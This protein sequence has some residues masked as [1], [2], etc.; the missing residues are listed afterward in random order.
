MSNFYGD[1][2]NGFGGTQQNGGY[3]PVGGYPNAPYQTPNVNN[4]GGYPN[5]GFNPPPPPVQ[6][7]PP[8]Q[9]VAPQ[10]MP[11]IMPQPV[12]QQEMMMPQEEPRKAKRKKNRKSEVKGKRKV[13]GKF[14]FQ[15]LLSLVFLAVMGLWYFKPEVI[16]TYIQLTT[17]GKQ[18]FDAVYAMIMSIVD[19]TFVFSWDIVWLADFAL[20][21][22]TALAALQFVFGLLS[23]AARKT[24]VFVK[25]NAFNVM[26]FALIFVGLVCWAN[27]GFDVVGIGSYIIAGD[28]ILLFILSII[29]K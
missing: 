1:Y 5:P 19:N 23:I 13:R 25:W 27:G 22:A 16:E 10:V 28:G 9:P 18:G 17:L 8:Q 29:G 14:I 24:S 2:N 6:Q 26:L 21:I 11:P 7:M 15:M 4:Y 12:P 3:P 20:T